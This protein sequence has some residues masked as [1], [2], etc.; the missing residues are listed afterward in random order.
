MRTNSK[1]DAFT[2]G[3]MVVVL[4]LTSIIIGLAFSVLTLVQKHMSGIQGNFNKNTE[5]NKLEQSLWL[6]FNRYSNIKYD[7]L[8]DV[9]VFKN[10]LDSVSYQFHESY[11]IKNKD[12]F[13]MEVQNKHIFFDG[14]LTKKGVLDAL[15]IETSK[16]FQNQILFVFKEND[17][18]HFVNNGL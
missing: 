6:D 14:N 7:A 13:N 5:L 16:V 3:E 15:K 9:I 1:I 17:A 4:I 12:T 10:Q 2:L 8:E 11:I 18:T